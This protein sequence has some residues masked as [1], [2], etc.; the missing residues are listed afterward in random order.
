[1]AFI[2][3]EKTKKYIGATFGDDKDFFNNLENGFLKINFDSIESGD[4]INIKILHCA[5]MG[6]KATGKTDYLEVKTMH[7]MDDVCNN[8]SHQYERIIDRYKQIMKK[9]EQFSNR[10]LLISIVLILASLASLFVLP[11]FKDYFP[12]LRIRIE[13]SK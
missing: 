2:D 11:K 9:T 10:V 5:P 12:D 8:C 6:L 13:A 7:S 4:F 3:L 1:M